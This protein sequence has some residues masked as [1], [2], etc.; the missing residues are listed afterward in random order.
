MN[1]PKVVKLRGVLIPIDFTQTSVPLS[2][3]KLSGGFSCF[4][5]YA[6]NWRL[7]VTFSFKAKE[8]CF[9]KRSRNQAGFD[10][11]KSTF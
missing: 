6:G 4:C 5:H 3:G 7:L 8:Q 10:G 1:S 2:S 9:Q 11:A